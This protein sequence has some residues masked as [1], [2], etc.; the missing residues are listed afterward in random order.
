[1]AWKAQENLARL[2]ECVVFLDE[3]LA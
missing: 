1:M 3:L 2:Q